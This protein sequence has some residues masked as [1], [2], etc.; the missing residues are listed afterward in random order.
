FYVWFYNGKR[1]S[2]S[3]QAGSPIMSRERVDNIP[4]G[5]YMDITVTWDSIP[6]GENDIYVFADKPISSGTYK[7]EGPDGKFHPDGDVLESRENDNDVSIADEFEDAIDLRPDLTITGIYFDDK[8]A[9][10]KGVT[11]TVTVANVG[12]AD[13]E[14]NTATVWIKIGGEKLK[15]KTTNSLNPLIPKEIEIDDELDIEF[16]WDVPDDAGKNVSVSARVAHPDD[17]NSR[18]DKLSTHVI[19]EEKRWDITGED[20]WEFAGIYLLVGLILGMAAFLGLYLLNTNLKDKQR[21]APSRP[22]LPYARPYH[23]PAP[24]PEVKFPVVNHCPNCGE[25]LRAYKPGRIRCPHCKTSAVVDI[26]GHFLPL[27]DFKAEYET[28]KFAHKQYLHSLQ[29]ELATLKSDLDNEESEAGKKEM[30][31]QVKNLEERI[32]FQQEKLGKIM[33]W[34]ET[35]TPPKEDDELERK[36]KELACLT[37][38]EDHPAYRDYIK[39]LQKQIKAMEAYA[40]RSAGGFPRTS[41]IAKRKEELSAIQRKPGTLLTLEDKA[42]LKHYPPKI[43]AFEHLIGMTVEKLL[44][45]LAIQELLAKLAEEEVE[46]YRKETEEAPEGEDEMLK[47]IEGRETERR[48]EAHEDE[49]E[50]KV[51]TWEAVAAEMEGIK[52]AEK[53]ADEETWMPETDKM[54]ETEEALEEAWDQEAY[55]LEKVKV[56]EGLEV[57][58]MEIEGVEGLQVEVVENT[59]RLKM[60][61]SRMLRLKVSRPDASMRGPIKDEKS[62]EAAEEIG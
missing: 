57:E 55:D 11:V 30:G 36:K 60:A 53:E 24:E 14:A 39:A 51:E 33:D 7:T 28:L 34:E 21:S 45:E 43:Q 54:E 13:A 61:R 38:Y 37:G 18:N 40:G 59:L 8:T 47:T 16:S 29:Q 25:K 44:E 23:K 46:E 5:Q 41:F 42:R 56:G 48:E 9:G 50:A 31:R 27:E 52:A 10:E 4:A 58:G 1:D 32:L 15:N 62:V 17:S 20:K 22:H 3:E 35:M 49:G 26:W 19:I 12:S 2:P 6:G